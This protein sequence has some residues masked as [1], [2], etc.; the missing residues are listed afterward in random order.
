MADPVVEPPWG[1]QIE[2][3]EM[4]APF[5]KLYVAAQFATDGPNGKSGALL[6][7]EAIKPLYE[8]D[9]QQLMVVH[10]D[11]IVYLGRIGD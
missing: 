9:G 1:V 11:G 8:V 6:A 7:A 4:T 3:D 2:A 10:R 5:S